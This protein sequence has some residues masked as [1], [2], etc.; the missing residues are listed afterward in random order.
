MSDQGGLVPPAANAVA[1]PAGRGDDV[2]VNRRRPS[3]SRLRAYLHL[4]YRRRWTVATAFTIVA[5]LGAYALTSQS[6]R[7]SPLLIGQRTRT[8]SRSEAPDQRKARLTITRRHAAQTLGRSDDGR[9]QLWSRPEFA[10]PSSPGVL[11]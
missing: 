7:G 3:E 8:W 11:A 9:A 2:R 1:L 10:P 6:I 5:V 4:L